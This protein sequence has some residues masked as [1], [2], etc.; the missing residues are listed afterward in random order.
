MAHEFAHALTAYSL[1]LRSTLF[2]YYTNIDF[3]S[4]DPSPRVLIAM[5]GPV[6]SLIFGLV[7]WLVYRKTRLKP[8]KLPWLYL[9]ILGISIFLGNL[10]AASFAGDF[11][12]AATILNVDPTI[13]LV[14]T[15]L[16]LALSS[17]FMYA[18][19]QELVK[20]SPPGSSRAA[21]ITSMIAWPALLGTVLVILAFLPLP[22]QFMAGW[23][24][25]S[26]FWLFAAGGASLASEYA[27]GG[28][29][30]RTRPVEYLAAAVAL[31]AVRILVAGASLA[32]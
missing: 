23:L 4:P 32:P 17:A 21:A 1:G 9:A 18:M 10:F 11:G 7:C 16:G 6:F 26:L 12:T 8:A 14:M 30:L 22:V 3:T 24:A 27:T 5:A 20:W 15:I 13:R 29:N 28:G 2:H 19:G 25:T 31:A